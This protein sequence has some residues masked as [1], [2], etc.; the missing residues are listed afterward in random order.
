MLT[1]GQGRGSHS[2]LVFAITGQ[3]SRVFGVAG[4]HDRKLT[5]HSEPPPAPKHSPLHCLNIELNKK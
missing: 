5:E 3:D 4:V 1:A 2:T